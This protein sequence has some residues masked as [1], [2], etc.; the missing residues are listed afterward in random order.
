MKKKYT[1]KYMYILEVNEHLR[2]TVYSIFF[3]DD[4][5]N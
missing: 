4:I 5:D 2:Y 1:I 3:G